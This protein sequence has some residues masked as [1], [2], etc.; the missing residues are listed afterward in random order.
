MIE[1]LEEIRLTMAEDLTNPASTA[2]WRDKC[3]S[4][5]K[6]CLE[7]KEENEYMTERCKELAHVAVSLM[8]QTYAQ[9]QQQQVRAS[10]SRDYFGGPS[11]KP[12]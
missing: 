8:N 5:Y 6:L 11:S 2:F 4:T 10:V 7:L 9:E 12:S 3:T 1:Q